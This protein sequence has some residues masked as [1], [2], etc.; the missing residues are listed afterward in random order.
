MTTKTT[1]TMLLLRTFWASSF[2]QAPELC[3]IWTSVPRRRT[4]CGCQPVCNSIWAPLAFLPVFALVMVS[5]SFSYYH[6]LKCSWCDNTVASR[7][8][9]SFKRLI[10]RLKILH[11]YTAPRG[12]FTEGLYF[13]KVGW[14]G[15]NSLMSYLTLVAVGAVNAVNVV[16][17]GSWQHLASTK[18]ANHCVF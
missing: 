10:E 12:L 2:C 17:V 8:W 15:H 16:H 5:I 13:A 14:P 11:D 4:F 18:L 6:S 7:S 3:L 9:P 1:T